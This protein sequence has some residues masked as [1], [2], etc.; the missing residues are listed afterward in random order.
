MT[1]ARSVA[2]GGTGRVSITSSSPTTKPISVVH[3][4]PN[5]S[6]GQPMYTVLSSVEYQTTDI[7]NATPPALGGVGLRVTANVGSQSGA[8][9]ATGG[10]HGLESQVIVRNNAQANAE[11]AAI[12]AVLRCDQDGVNG[13]SAGRA[14]LTDMTVHGAIGTQQQILTGINVVLAN[15]YNGQP[16]EN[17]SCAISASAGTGIGGSLDAAHAAATRYPGGDGLWVGGVTS[18]SAKGFNYG[19]RIGGAGGPWNVQTSKVGTAFQGRDYDTA[20]LHLLTR[21]GT[22]APAIH[23]AA[24]AGHILLGEQTDPAA[25]AANFGALYVRDNGAGKTQLVV[26]FPTGAIQV[27]ATEP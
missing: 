1:I 8:I 6:G 11:H 17:P 12:Y 23:I 14:W 15:Y 5:Q 18:G 10:F 24:D 9:A 7:T 2:S 20:G 25:P 22:T 27:I 16:S 13:G 21:S 26:R 19:V 4:V 3:T